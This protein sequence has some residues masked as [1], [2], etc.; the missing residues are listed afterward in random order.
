ME[1]ETAFI[2]KTYTHALVQAHT[3]S[4]MTSARSHACMK[5]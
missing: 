2:Q 1:Q 3:R 4:S 5:N